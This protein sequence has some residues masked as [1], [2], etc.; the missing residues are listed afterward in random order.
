MLA[1]QALPQ[2]SHLASPSSTDPLEGQRE[3][4]YSVQELNLEHEPGQLCN[5]SLLNESKVPLG[6]IALA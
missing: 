2:L 4:I 3:V 1:W 5:C 6:I